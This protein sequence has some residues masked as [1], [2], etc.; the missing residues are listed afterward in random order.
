M[1]V[2]CKLSEAVKEIFGV[3][4]FFGTIF[5]SPTYRRISE[6]QNINV[7]FNSAKR[8]QNFMFFIH[9]FFGKF[10]RNAERK[11]IAY[12]ASRHGSKRARTV[13]Q[14]SS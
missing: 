5:L 6:S 7:T 2:V 3:S 12:E 1:S 11:D 13:H 14:P 8:S 10:S 9:L 4:Y